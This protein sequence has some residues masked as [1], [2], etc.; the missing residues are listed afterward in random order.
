MSLARVILA[1][2]AAGAFFAA[3]TALEILNRGVG[4][5]PVG[6]VW[7]LLMWLILALTLIWL[8]RRDERRVFS[9]LPFLRQ[10]PPLVAVLQPW[11]AVYVLA[12]FISNVARDTAQK[13]PT[14]AWMPPAV[15]DIVWFPA[16]ALFPESAG[17]SAS[18]IVVLAFGATFAAQAVLYAAIAELLGRWICRRRADR[19]G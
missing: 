14:A 7:A 8:E 13:E 3:G 9:E 16:S 12:A 4:V 10:R 15:F 1:V 6:S 2:V 17:T 19:G 5:F 18:T 11:L